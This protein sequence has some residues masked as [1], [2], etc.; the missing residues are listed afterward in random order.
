MQHR[1][2]LRGGPFLGHGMEFHCQAFSQASSQRVIYDLQLMAPA[3]VDDGETFLEGC[4]M[5]VFVP[6]WTKWDVLEVT[7]TV[8]LSLLPWHFHSGMV[9]LHF[10]SSFVAYSS[11]AQENRFT[12]RRDN[13]EE[14]GQKG[15]VFDLHTSPFWQPWL[16]SSGCSP[17]LHQGGEAWLD[18]VLH[19]C[20]NFLL[21]TSVWKVNLASGFSGL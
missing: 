18:C 16:V 3:S 1:S 13:Q 2:L 11:K 15:T 17:A 9:W 12:R 14:P 21:N 19:L 4:L 10:R 7:W 8:F 5:F 20:C 6:L